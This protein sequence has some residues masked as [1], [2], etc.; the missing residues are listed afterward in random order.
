MHDAFRRV[1]VVHFSGDGGVEADNLLAG[2][3]NVSL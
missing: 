3:G 1:R 2:E